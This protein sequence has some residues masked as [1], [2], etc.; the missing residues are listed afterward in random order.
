MLAFN[1]C[2]LGE[3]APPSIWLPANVAAFLSNSSVIS[4]S[5]SQQQETSERL[6]TTAKSGQ[7]AA[8][9]DFIKIVGLESVCMHV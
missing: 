5:L 2:S 1:N 7:T 6:N 3:A 9:I 8:L 4:G